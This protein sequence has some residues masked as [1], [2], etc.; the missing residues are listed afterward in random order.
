MGG[1]FSSQGTFVNVWRHFCC[2]NQGRCYWH[3]VVRHLGSWGTMHRTVPTKRIIW[4]QMSTVLR[5]SN[6][7]TTRHRYLELCEVLDKCLC[8]AACQDAC[9]SRA[10]PGRE[11]SM[12]ASPSAAT[13]YPHYVD[14]V[15]GGEVG[16]GIFTFSLE[17]LL[18]ILKLLRW[19]FQG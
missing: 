13:S 17:S 2:Y 11:Q 14:F 15:T 9:G 3:L 8:P 16:S 10:S 5:L 1:K 7:D 4:S 19:L 18:L 6:P 12:A